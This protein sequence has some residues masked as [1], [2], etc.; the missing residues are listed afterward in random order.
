MA[1]SPSSQLKQ[2][3]KAFLLAA[4]YWKCLGSSTLPR[5][6]TRNSLKRYPPELD[7]CVA[8]AMMHLAQAAAQ[9]CA[10]VVAMCSNTAKSALLSKLA[11][12]VVRDAEDCLRFFGQADAK[13]EKVNPDV[14]MH[15]AYLR[16]FFTSFAMF[17]HAQELVDARKVGQALSAY[18]QSTSK[19]KLQ[20]CTGAFNPDLP[21]LPRS[22]IRGSVEHAIGQ[23]LTV[24]NEQREKY[25]KENELIFFQ[26]ISHAPLPSAILLTA[27]T[28][29][30]LP[31]SGKIVSFQKTA[32]E[33]VF[34]SAT[35]L[36]SVKVT[37]NETTKM[38]ACSACTFINSE[39]M[40]KCEMCG[41]AL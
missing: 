23:L 29:F 18:D 14:Y 28:E 15:A 34:D 10:I 36:S 16:D 12:A 20:S 40:K 41:I 9:Q 19:L 17:Q 5:W 2:A 11:A 35:T 6:V 25:N 30:K 33:S 24:L 27:A 22:L 1:S 3:S 32:L 31:S 37:E 21:G 4:S 13:C 39:D 8:L 38:T 7:E 26:V